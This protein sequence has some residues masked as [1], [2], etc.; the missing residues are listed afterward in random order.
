MP[1]KIIVNGAQGKMGLEAVK[2]INNDE[3]LQ[4]VGT[5]GRQDD[6]PTAVKTSGAEVVLD[7][8]SAHC[9]FENAMNIIESGARPVIG[10]S[11]LTKDQ[12]AQL[13]QRCLKEKLGAI[14]AP[15][16]SIGAILM[17]RFAQEA[18][19]Y[20]P[21]VEIVEMHSHT[22][23]DAP[24]ST[25]LRT[26][27]MMAETKAKLASNLQEKET[28]AGAR[29]GRYQDIPIHSV[30]LPGLVAHQSVIFGDVGQTLTISDNTSSR[31]AFMPGVVLACQKVIDLDHLVYGLETLL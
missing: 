5:L 31:E 30:R 19:R 24:S 14:I 11:G 7:F 18:A 6:L 22:K 1:I 8:T 23:V 25:A 26:A 21:H 17:M 9:V 15:N 10:T 16:F 29:G 13:S 12:V 4:L 20:F 27:E 2:A 28:V 3:G